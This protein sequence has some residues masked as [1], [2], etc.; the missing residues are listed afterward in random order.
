MHTFCDNFG[1]NRVQGQNFDTMWAPIVGTFGMSF[2]LLLP[3]LLM[4]LGFLCVL[5][6]VSKL[7]RMG[8]NRPAG[9]Q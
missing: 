1:I 6:N 3:L 8:H 2:S 7:V 4:L 5:A 9:A